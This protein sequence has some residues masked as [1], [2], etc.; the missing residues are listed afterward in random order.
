MVFSGLEAVLIK[1]AGI[2]LD[3]RDLGKTLGQMKPKLERLH[4][5]YGAHVCGEGGEY[6]TL[7]LDSPLFKKRIV[8]KE[9]ETVI[10][11]DASF[12]SVSYLRIKKAELVEK[13]A[14]T[15]AKLSDLT[16]PPELDAIGEKTLAAATL[17]WV[18]REAQTIPVDDGEASSDD[19][20]PLARPEGEHAVTARPLVSRRGR[21]IGIHN[22]VG[23]KSESSVS[24]SLESEVKLAFQMLEAAIKS[25]APTL[26]LAN[27]SH[28]NLHLES[29][30]LFPLVNNEYRKIFG[31]GPPT[32]ACV[33]V[34]TR[35]GPYNPA[36]S[37]QTHS[38]SFRISAVAYDDG[39]SC[40]A[41]LDLPRVTVR[42]ALHVQGR[43]YWAPANIGPYSQSVT[44]GE[45]IF[46]AGQIG[47]RPT[48]LELPSSLNYTGK[49]REVALSL[50]H[51]RRVV[52]ATL[53]SRIDK[54]RGWIEGGVCWLEGSKVGDVKGAKEAERLK[55]SAHAAW[56][57][58][59]RSALKGLG[60]QVEEGEDLVDDDDGGRI[61]GED[62]G[63]GAE[64]LRWDSSWLGKN[65][66]AQEIPLLY[67]TVPH[68]ALPKG[69]AIEW[70]LTAHTGRSVVTESC[71]AGEPVNE[72]ECEDETGPVGEGEASPI[73]T[74]SGGFDMNLDDEQRTVA[75][76]RFKILESARGG[77]SF[78]VAAF[79]LCRSLGDQQPSG[80]DQDSISGLMNHL[81][82]RAFS[83]SAFY[84]SRKG[85]SHAD[86]ERLVKKLTSLHILLGGVSVPLLPTMPVPVSDLHFPTSDSNPSQ[87]FD[88]AL[89]W[90][91]V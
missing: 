21:W 80:W 43:S 12:A 69:A 31:S 24:Q 51:V 53:E 15:C 29:Q 38:P 14:A 66:L 87:G 60:K 89:V 86:I 91:G 71:I 61:D 5:L 20:P 42:K 88:M 65:T 30:R 57:S 79:K 28:I 8:L 17:E 27:V 56:I 22:L 23:T 7:T 48:L 83:T 11:S 34:E 73:K 10:H 84:A 52:K 85:F 67:A 33:E 76:C 19:F 78:G 37:G 68:G 47:L 35:T 25:Q 54:G 44:V 63:L 40:D 77:A 16:V 13:D 36:S 18:S 64:D 55:R 50:Q 82:S 58:Q 2:G 3:E 1:V 74:N 70:Q 4:S 32:R 9:V 90:H 41:A 6:E 45:R 59:S 26:S 46:I 72:D 39:A 49:L 81:S 62:D 75:R